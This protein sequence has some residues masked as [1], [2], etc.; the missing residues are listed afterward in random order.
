MYSTVGCVHSGTPSS[1][2]YD[3]YQA[4]QTFHF[5]FIKVVQTTEYPMDFFHPCHHGHARAKVRIS[6]LFVGVNNHESQ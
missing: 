1:S 6:A 2:F 5:R 3:I 4:L